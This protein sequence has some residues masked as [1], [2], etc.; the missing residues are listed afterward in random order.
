[1]K[2][3]MDF[4]TSELLIILASV[5]HYRVCADVVHPQKDTPMD[6]RQMALRNKVEMAIE[7]R[8][9]EGRK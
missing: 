9:K 8:T 1:M 5:D 3:P 4:S 6:Q 2:R 7:E